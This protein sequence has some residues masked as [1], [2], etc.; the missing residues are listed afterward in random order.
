MN[1]SRLLLDTNII[2]YLLDGDETLRDILEGRQVYVSFVT[3]LELYG[4]KQTDQSE[5]L[6]GDCIKGGY[7]Q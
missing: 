5:N 4:F 6:W 1:G 2:L 7:W 3:E